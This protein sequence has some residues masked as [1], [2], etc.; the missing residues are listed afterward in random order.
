MKNLFQSPEM[1]QER[2]VWGILV[3]IAVGLAFLDS[4]KMGLY[5]S[6]VCVIFTGLGL[7]SVYRHNRKLAALS[8]QID[9]VLH[10]EETINFQD[11]NEGAFSILQSEL[12]KMT[13]RLREQ[14]YQLQR[15]KTC[16]AD[17]IADISHQIRTPLTSI[18][19]LL[20]MLSQ[21]ELSDKRRLQILHELS[22]LLDRID[23]LITAL[24][25]MSRLDAGVVQFEPEPI[26][27]ETLIRQAADPLLIALELREQ[28]LTI[29]ADG[30]LVV[31]RMWTG[32][33]ICNI[34]KNCMEHTPNGGHIQVNASENALYS[35]IC[36]MDEGTGISEKDLPHVFER[37][38]KGENSNSESF[39]I[40]L[41]LARMIVAS[42][43]GNIK[44]ENRAHGG[45][46]F[47][48]RFYKGAV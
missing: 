24:L 25:K 12:H 15:D 34:L 3:L 27:L 29:Q 26:K 32:E 36:I 8:A 38:Y 40:G 37:F 22:S 47:T 14:K 21:P 17:S 31:D 10:G 33:A 2:T 9:A 5:T 35:E 16:L 13:V 43:H 41:A 23:R 48:I 20:S 4:V 46:V 19:L 42:Q 7:F 11:Y 6:F 30:I 18:N 44:V 28:A 45:V 1:R 39:G